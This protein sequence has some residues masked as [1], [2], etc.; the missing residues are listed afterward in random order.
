MLDPLAAVVLPP[1]EGFGH[2]RAGAL[3]LLARRYAATPGFRTLVI[4][5]PQD[6]PVFPDV[7]FSAVTPRRWWPGN[8]NLRFA[9][10]MIAPL[11]AAQPALIEVH[12]RPE[13]AMALA[14]RFPSIPVGLLLNNDPVGMRAA[15][16]PAARAHLLRI[17]NPVMASSDYLR[18]RFME[19]VDPAAGSVAVLHNCLDI[20]A[21][22][23][24]GPRENVIL[25]AGRVVADK[26]PDSFILACAQ[27]LKD[28]PGWRAEMIGADG[29]RADGRETEYVRDIQRLAARSNVHMAG[30][31]DHAGV[32][33]AM[34]RAAI[35]IT[36]SRWNEPF[37]LTA[38]E[39]LA[40]GAPLIVSPRGGLPEVAGGAAVYAN[41]DDPAEIAAA[42][43]ALAADPVRRA[44][45]SAMGRVRAAGFDTKIAAGRLA[46]LRRVALTRA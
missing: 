46:A 11:R 30:Y 18:R 35:V 7:P 17:L 1:R 38:L 36:P 4:G 14:R 41:P 22:P 2:G 33:S 3:G 24:E 26:G 13:I 31:L 5:G 19:G 23:P 28:L 32:L 25:F 34:S 9:A 16:S 20:D 37:G 12:N 44:E 40:C 6:G 15:S 45:L 29:M 8:V 39:A 21:V 10:A 27:V 43:M 42:I